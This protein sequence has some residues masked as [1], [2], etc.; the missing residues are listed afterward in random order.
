MIYKYLWYYVSQLRTAIATWFEFYNSNRPHS[1]FAEANREEVYY[2]G[3]SIA[4]MPKDS[5]FAT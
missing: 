2:R 3:N 4:S 1:T 5:K